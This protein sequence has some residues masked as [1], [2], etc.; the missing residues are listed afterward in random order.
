MIP[1][2]TITQ[3]IF[4]EQSAVTFTKHESNVTLDH[5]T[6]LKS[7]GYIYSN[8]QIWV[9]I[10]DFTF[11]PKIIA[12]LSKDHVSWRYLVNVLP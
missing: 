11:M 10:I 12:K 3:V 4:R 7:L 5:K 9:K 8:S 6:S 1:T 2:V